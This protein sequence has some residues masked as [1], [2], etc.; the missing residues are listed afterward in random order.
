[1]TPANLLA[2][3][4]MMASELNVSSFPVKCMSNRNDRYNIKNEMKGSHLGGM[5]ECCFSQGD[6]KMENFKDSANPMNNPAK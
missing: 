5:S 1:M 4:I 3:P 2:H 6:T